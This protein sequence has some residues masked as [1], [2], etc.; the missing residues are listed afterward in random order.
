ML[1]RSSRSLAR[2]GPEAARLDSQHAPQVEVDRVDRAR[3]G[4]LASYLSDCWH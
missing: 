3:P 2:D 4:N 1:L